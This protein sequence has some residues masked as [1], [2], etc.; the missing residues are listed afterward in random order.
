MEKTNE[1]KMETVTIEKKKLQKLV[2]NFYEVCSL[3]DE[4]NIYEF[5]EGDKSMQKMK[6]W[7]DKNFGR[8]L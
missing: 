7:V 4:M 1:K 6:E 8:Q 2:D 3:C 5:E